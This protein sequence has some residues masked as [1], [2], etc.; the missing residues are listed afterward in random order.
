MAR[1]ALQ[2]GCGARGTPRCRRSEDERKGPAR[3][4]RAPWR[5]VGCAGD[6][7]GARS[8]LPLRASTLPQPSGAGMG[9]GI[10]R[11]F[12]S[13]KLFHTPASAAAW[14]IV[15]SM[16]PRILASGGAWRD[17]GGR[18]GGATGQ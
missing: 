15:G 4:S 17:R 9:R 3:R 8:S 5:T 16:V 18:W 7:D 11:P 10:F 6:I 2:S 12:L 14:G 13:L 1:L